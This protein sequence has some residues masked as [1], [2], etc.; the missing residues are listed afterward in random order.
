MTITTFIWLYLNKSHNGLL[1]HYIFHMLAS[2]DHREHHILFLTLFDLTSNRIFQ[3][4]IFILLLQVFIISSSELNLVSEIQNECWII[5]NCPNISLVISRWTS[6]KHAFNVVI[7]WLDY[8]LHITANC[9]SNMFYWAITM[10]QNEVIH[11]SNE[12]TQK[13]DLKYSPT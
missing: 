2:I 12:M 5:R 8:A 13:V 11:R 9:H 10:Y 6:V 1:K 3:I 4:Y 7:F